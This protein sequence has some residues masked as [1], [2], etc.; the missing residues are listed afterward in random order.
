[1]IV[2]GGATWD[3]PFSQ[4]AQGG[5]WYSIAMASSTVDS[6]YGMSL[7][8]SRYDGVYTSTSG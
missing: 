4:G 3:E 6:F 1:M 8:A 5:Q 7:I 2:I